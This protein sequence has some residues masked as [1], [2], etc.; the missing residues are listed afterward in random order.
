MC[1]CASQVV[2]GGG[3]VSIGGVRFPPQ[4]ELTWVGRFSAV[5]AFGGTRIVLVNTT[6]LRLGHGG[7]GVSAGGPV[8]FITRGY[9]II[10]GLN[11]RHFTH[12]HGRFFRWRLPVVIQT[13]F[14][15]PVD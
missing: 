15:Q 1:G 13:T 2:L 4:S 12:S 7:F 14:P 9:H 5:R 11:A 3:W 8:G 6:L 10:E